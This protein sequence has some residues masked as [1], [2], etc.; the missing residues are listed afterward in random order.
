M[1]HDLG[2][3]TEVNILDSGDNLIDPATE[4]TLAQIKAVLDTIESNTDDL[5][6]KAENINLNTDDIEDKLDTL[7][8]DLTGDLNVNLQDGAGNDITSTPETGGRRSLDVNISGGT[9]S[10]D[11]VGIKDSGDVRIDP[12]T[13]DTLQE[14]RDA[15]GLGTATSLLDQLQAIVAGLDVKLHDGAGTD[16]TSSPFSGGIQA[17]DVNVVNQLEDF[18]GE[19]GILNSGDTR[20]NPAE[21]ETLQRVVDAIGEETGENVL[22]KLDNLDTQLQAVIDTLDVDLSTRASEAT[23][24]S[25][26][27]TVGEESGVTVLSKLEALVDRLNYLFGENTGEGLGRVNLW[28]GETEVAVSPPATGETKGRLKVDAQLSSSS[29]GYADVIIRDDENNRVAVTEDG[30]LKVSQEV[31]AP[32]DTTPVKEGFDE[33]T[34]GKQGGTDNIN[35][36]IPSGETLVLQ[37]FEAGAY[38]PKDGDYQVQAKFRLVYQPN[39]S[40]TGEETLAIIYFNG[41]SD[42]F[43]DLNFSTTGDGTK[44]LRIEATNWSVQPIEQTTFFRGYY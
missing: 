22:S 9:V 23:L 6:I 24:Q 16:L 40:S 17:L 39:G 44:R 12:A 41:Q 30:R 33:E 42:G 43:R 35:W 19:V 20:V 34:T 15:I 29:T 8:D 4:T 25:L 5:E 11:E 38:I 31:S 13:E 3:V 7:H 21:E 2:K 28:D 27:N 1:L 10:I 18:S 14:V 32:P 36:I 26:L 37:K